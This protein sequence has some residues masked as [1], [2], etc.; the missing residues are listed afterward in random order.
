MDYRATIIPTRAEFASGSLE[1]TTNALK[2]QIGLFRARP[3]VLTLASLNL[4]ASA[5]GLTSVSIFNA[6]GFLLAQVLM[7]FYCLFSIAQARRPSLEQV[8]HLTHLVELDPSLAAKVNALDDRDYSFR[9]IGKFIFENSARAN[10]IEMEQALNDLD[11]A[12]SGVN[13]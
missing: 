4:A 11:D 9:K 7:L 6:F 10:E 5:L 12:V 2:A 1:P 8:R 3:Y 13:R